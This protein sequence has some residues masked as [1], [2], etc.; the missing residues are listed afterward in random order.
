MIDPNKLN[1]IFID[2]LFKDE[3]IIDGKPC[4]SPINVNG[5]I[6]NVGFHSE[7][8]E[9]HRA[10]IKEMLDNLP[11][12]FQPSSK[13]GGGGM[14]FLN[15]C[16]DKNGIQWGE[17]RNMEQLCILSIGLNLGCFP[18]PKN[19]WNILPGGVPYFSIKE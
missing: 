10:E 17:H 7:R 6:S 16:V 13:G 18:L 15:M 19:M 1:T 3:E 12:E 4:I 14:T 8:L 9:S 5:I 11:I 2:C